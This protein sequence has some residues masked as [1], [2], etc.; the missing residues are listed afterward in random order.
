MT[1]MLRVLLVTALVAWIAQPTIGGGGE[2]AGGSGVWILPRAGALACSSG[3]PQGSPRAEFTVV[4][5]TSALRLQV[6]NN[7][8]IAVASLVEDLSGTPMPLP[9]SGYIVEVPSAML[10]AVGALPTPHA[11]VLIS[12]ANQL[13][14]VLKLE[15]DAPNDQVVVKVW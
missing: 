15:V 2:N 12:D 4:G 5:L 7:M 3:M 1:S 13:G 9:V 6:S 10:I 14:Y 11:R 8:G